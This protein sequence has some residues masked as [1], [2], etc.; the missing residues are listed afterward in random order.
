MFKVLFALKRGSNVVVTFDKDESLQTI[1]FGEP[2]G[3]PGAMLPNPSRQ[4]TRHAD[5]KGSVRPIGHD[6]NPSAALRHEAN[7]LPLGDGSDLG[8]KIGGF[9]LDALAEREPGESGELERCARVLGHRLDNLGDP[10][11]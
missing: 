4:I 7:R 10:T 5:V 2:I 3:D 6:V 11:L 8:G 1:S 9:L